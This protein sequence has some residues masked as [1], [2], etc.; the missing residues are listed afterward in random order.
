M[1]GVNGVIG[2]SRV[3]LDF[4]GSV[5][6]KGQEVLAEG[7]CLNGPKRVDFYESSLYNK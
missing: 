7:G 4:H 5:K 6:P 1:Q 3:D 2:S